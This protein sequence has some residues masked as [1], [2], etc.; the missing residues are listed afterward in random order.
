MRYL[1]V[2]HVLPER[3]RLRAP[4][5]RKDAAAATAVAEAVAALPGV[6]E[7]KVR[8]YTGSILIEHEREV[9]PATL[10]DTAARALTAERVIPLGEAPPPPTEVP[11]LSRLAQLAALAVHEIDRAVMLR[12]KGSIDLGTLATLGFFT[13]GAVE[14]A[15]KREVHTPPWFN[16]AWWGYRTFSQSE[17]EEIEAVNH[18]I[19]ANDS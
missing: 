18:D 13:A 7:I 4:W 8:P 10:V 19:K 9:V 17:R 11:R 14:V 6:H 12:T 3:T 15:M 16:L 1:Q 2:V 5:L